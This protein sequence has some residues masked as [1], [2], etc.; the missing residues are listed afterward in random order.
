[1]LNMNSLNMY[2]NGITSVGETRL[3]HLYANYEG[4]NRAHMSIDLTNLAEA[5][6]NVDSL[7]EDL[8][9]FLQHLLETAEHNIILNPIQEQ[10]E[11]I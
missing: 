10:T 7:A 6:E 8:K 4:D 11:M 1:M 9:A 5:R 3:A 2:F